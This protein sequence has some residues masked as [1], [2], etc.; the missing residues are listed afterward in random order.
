MVM[1]DGKCESRN[2]LLVQ[3]KTKYSKYNHLKAINAQHLV[4]A[5]W[6]GLGFMNNHEYHAGIKKEYTLHGPE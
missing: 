6:V 5:D 3:K 1:R 4:C 2:I